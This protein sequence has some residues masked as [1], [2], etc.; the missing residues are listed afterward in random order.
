MIV[1]LILSS[2]ILAQLGAAA[3]TLWLIR[4]TG[5]RLVWALMATAL[6]VMAVHPSVTLYHLVSG[7]LTQ[8]PN[9]ASTG[10]ALGVS[11]LI[12]TGVALFFPLL[13]SIMRSEK[14]HRESESRLRTI[15]QSAPDFIVQLDREGTITFIN[16]A[17]PGFTVDKLIG[18]NY[19]DWIPPGRKTIEGAIDRVFEGGGPQAFEVTAP[20][21]SG[22]QRWYACH[23]GPVIVDDRVVSA[24][25]IAV[26]VTDRKRTA[27]A[28]QKSEERYRTLVETIPHGIQENDTSGII[29]FSSS[30]HHRMLGYDEGEL[31]GK[32]IW[33][34]NASDAE[35]ERLR[36]LLATLVQDQP[37][38]T[39]YFAK[40]RTKDGRVIDVQVDWNYKRDGR[41]RV[42]G[43]TSIVTDITERKRAEGVLR[44]SEER[45]RQLAEY[46][47]EVFWLHDVEPQQIIYVSPAYETIWGRSLQ[48]LYENPLDWAEAIHP[49]DRPRVLESFEQQMREGGPFDQEYRIV[50]PDGTI[51]W[52]HDRGFAIRNDEGKVY[53]IAGAAKDVTERKQ[54]EEALRESTQ[55]VSVLAQEQQTLLDHTRDFLYRHDTRGVFNYL[56]PA[57]EQIT[58][59]S[60]EEWRR[61][62]TTYMTD[63]PVNEKVIECTEETLRTGRE[64][65]PYLVEIRARDGRPIMIEVN[66]RPY[67]E[68]NKVAGIVGVAR[69]V[70]ERVQAEA[71]LKE[72]KEAAE[73]ASRAKSVFLANM[74]HEIRTPIMA[75]LGAAE[76]AGS[77]GDIPTDS[78]DRRDVIL[79]N[80][81]YL[82]A[83]VD[84][85]LDV[86][87]LEAD[88]L[89]VQ[90]VSC[91]LSEILADVRAV[92]APLHMRD[93][94]EFK[95]HFDT[96]IPTLIHTDP[97]R[98]KQAIINLVENAFKFVRKGHVHVRVK[99]D[100]FGPEPRLSVA[101]Q[102]TGSGIAPGALDR[103]FETFT[104]LGPG[105]AGILK[106]VGL[107]LPLA[108][109]I[110]EQLG[111]TLEVKSQV[112][113]GSTFTLRV[114]TGS[115]E[116]VEWI[117]ADEVDLPAGLLAR[118]G[119][120]GCFPQVRGSVLLAEDFPDTRELLKQALTQAG[121]EVTV[122]HNGRQA[123]EAAAQREFDLI[124][125]DVRM[126]ELDG[127]SAASQLR[128]DGCKSAIIALTAS[129][130]PNERARALSAGFDD[131]W[132]KPI[133]LERLVHEASAYL[134]TAPSGAGEEADPRITDA[135][136]RRN[137]SSIAAV[138][139]EFAGSL[140]ARVH[141]VREALEA[142][143]LPRAEDILHQLVGAGGIHGFMELSH[144][145]ARVLALVRDG[146]LTGRV[147]EL[148][149][150]EEL[151]RKIATSA[152]L[153]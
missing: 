27:H 91:S 120:S 82:L 141:S 61:H 23:V 74:S 138:V 4:V 60:V 3:L 86:A 21:A 44:E 136:S 102:D 104:Q 96:R 133:S 114:N 66:E 40:N 30:G 95:I 115:L 62:Y 148:I 89:A 93:G 2:T 58:G 125:L 145:A 105:T 123:V 76:L 47:R 122:V 59:Y 153:T 83:L 100:R 80:G 49:E 7:T 69:D 71:A 101:V 103:I 150:L 18:T 78:L 144:E 131:V 57:V 50:R 67:F 130:E 116:G 43:F 41:G 119:G 17:A 20:G 111:G 29:T 75:M 134:D 56:S 113:R 31:Y 11:V 22:L 129:T 112:G 87:R 33:D 65:P 97:T 107:G 38:P 15:T 77:S 52:I 51:R 88:K 19:K 54:A 13:R 12:L 143:N 98:L 48:G 94:V 147:E 14:S 25:I 142:D 117:K 140:E 46:V 90:C 10:T 68:N 152:S 26:D 151:V 108:R 79:R 110:A 139:A 70:T 85:L 39:P 72:A 64:S 53:R 149:K 146:G 5:R 28:L 124:V 106:G 118:G 36:K 135:T 132:P 9:P 127:V 6:A 42:T 121:A 35:G 109:G 8:P 73:A 34:L 16:R 1:T 84:G 92:I 63:N 32:A 55:K 24:I 128:R 45:F 81:R 126:P 37:P 99:I 137:N